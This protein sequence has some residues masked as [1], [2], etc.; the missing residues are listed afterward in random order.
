ML[1]NTHAHF[2]SHLQR[3]DGILVLPLP[4][5]NG[6]SPIR[7]RGTKAPVR[8]VWHTQVGRKKGE[9]TPVRRWE[10]H[11]TRVMRGQSGSPGPGL[12]VTSQSCLPLKLVPA[13]SKPERPWTTHHAQDVRKKLLQSY[14]FRCG[15]CFKEM[16]N[17]TCICFSEE[18]KKKLPWKD[19]L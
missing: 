18:K 11:E 1:W 4:A 3:C 5:V 14:V 8:Q 19:P 2:F 10:T 16:S 9:R 17:L 15:K 7:G 6:E 13:R 12:P